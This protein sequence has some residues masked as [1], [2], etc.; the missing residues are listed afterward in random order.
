MKELDKNSVVWKIRPQWMGNRYTNANIPYCATCNGKIHDIAHKFC[1]WCGTPLTLPEPLT[2]ERLRE[3]E[4]EP[5][6][7]AIV[8]EWYIISNVEVVDELMAEI[9]MTDYTVVEWDETAPLPQF[10][11]VV[12]KQEP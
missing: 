1:G 8:Q 10:Y 6:Y 7:D 2:L 4:G 12:P 9:H 11:P 5:V 3:M